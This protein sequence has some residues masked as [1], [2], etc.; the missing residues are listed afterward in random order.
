MTSD[1]TMTPLFEAD[2]DRTDWI[3]RHAAYFTAIRG[4]GLNRSREEYPSKA[5]ALADQ[6]GDG[7]SLIYAVAADDAS[8][9]ICNI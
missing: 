4:R 8:A 5:E 9:H 3:E 6:P 7:Q 1:D 2:A